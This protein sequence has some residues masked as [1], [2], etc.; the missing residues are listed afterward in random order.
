MRNR[1][2]YEMTFSLFLIMNDCN[3]WFFFWRIPFLLFCTRTDPAF[4][5]ICVLIRAALPTTSHLRSAH[6]LSGEEGIFLAGRKR[7]R[8]RAEWVLASRAPFDSRKSG[9]CTTTEN[10]FSRIRI[11]A[12]AGYLIVGF[13]AKRRG[14][15]SLKGGFLPLPCAQR[16]C[17]RVRVQ[18]SFFLYFFPGGER[19]ECVCQNEG[20]SSHS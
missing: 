7:E 1:K 12:A 17:S 2:W 6:R 3:A 8:E 13:D 4:A 5:E 10:F 16:N 15:L 19:S 14:R 11:M 18:N 9:G 20:G